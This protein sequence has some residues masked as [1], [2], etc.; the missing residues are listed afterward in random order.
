MTLG[1]MIHFNLY[2][3]LNMI[4]SYMLEYFLIIKVNITY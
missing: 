3:V 1:L 4:H 2:C